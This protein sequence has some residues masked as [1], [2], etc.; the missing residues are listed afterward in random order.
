[1][2]RKSKSFDGGPVGYKRPPAEHQF[3][4]GHKRLGGRAKGQ[5]NLSTFIYELLGAKVT[6]SE[7]GRTRKISVTEALLLRARAQGFNG[8]VADI[9]RFFTLVG[10]HE[11]GEAEREPLVI[12]FQQVEGDDLW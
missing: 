9:D 11:P 10:K 12:R 4:K 7:N 3:K 5:K 6:V 8:S 1:M 2:S